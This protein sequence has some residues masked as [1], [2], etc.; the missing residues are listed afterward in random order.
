MV[1][2]QFLLDGFV[3]RE[4]RIAIQTMPGLFQLA[5]GP[6]TN[7]TLVVARHVFEVGAS[8]QVFRLAVWAFQ[9]FFII[10]L[11][12]RRDERT[13]KV[14]SEHL[15]RYSSRATLPTCEAKRRDG[16]TLTTDKN[17]IEHRPF[18]NACET[19]AFVNRVCIWQSILKEVAVQIWDSRLV[20]K[21]EF[22]DS[23]ASNFAV[24]AV[25]PNL[26]RS[27]YAPCVESSSVESGRRDDQ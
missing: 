23:A 12:Q 14:V 1:P 19:P 15:V 6:S 7:I 11:S 13:G 26:V 9:R 16:S 21:N 20:S 3:S 18:Q 10:E 27:H 5:V 17:S 22:A 8:H 25:F 2:D 4:S 24:D